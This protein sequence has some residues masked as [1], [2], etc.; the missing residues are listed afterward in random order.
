M[1]LVAGQQP[2]VGTANTHRHLDIFRTCRL[3]SAR[4]SNLKRWSYTTPM[5]TLPPDI[6]R[7]IGGYANWFPFRETCRLTRSAIQPSVDDKVKCIVGA[8]SPTATMPVTWL[9]TTYNIEIH[10]VMF[11]RD[12]SPYNCAYKIH[13]R[14]Y[15]ACRLGTA[16]A[17]NCIYPYLDMS[18]ES[19]IEAAVCLAAR[20]GHLELLKYMSKVHR[21]IPWLYHVADGRFDILDWLIPVTKASLVPDLDTM[22]KTVMIGSWRNLKYLYSKGFV[23]DDDVASEVI[24]SGDSQLLEWVQSTGCRFGPKSMRAGILKG[25]DRVVT[26]LLNLECTVDS[27]VLD[28]AGFVGDLAM[29]KKLRL[30]GCEWTSSMLQ[31]AAGGRH[32][33]LI[34]WAILEGCPVDVWVA[35]EVIRGKLVSSEDVI[36]AAEMLIWLVKH[37]C[38]YNPA[39]VSAIDWSTFH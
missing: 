15:L 30:L 7:V 6:I 36:A 26:W 17:F 21:R 20:M 28:V 4:S 24:R 38:K 25:D 14:V 5:Q 37:G 29:I 22:K 10:R 8:F 19:D 27:S 11:A 35:T 3:L 2:A 16:S 31:H 23:V 1:V 39:L 34:K 32:Y 9:F 18:G 33:D 12:T 13:T